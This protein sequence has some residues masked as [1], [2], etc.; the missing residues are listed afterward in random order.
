[1]KLNLGCG[2]TAREGYVNLDIIPGAADV[3]HDLETVPMPFDDNTFEE[4]RAWHVL[5]HIKNLLQLMQELHR[6]AKPDCKFEIVVPY[7]SH[8]AAFEDPTHVR[9]FFSNSF[10]YFAQTAFG[11]V[12]YGYRGDWQPLER[13]I[14][15]PPNA[16]ALK[17]YDEAMGVVNSLRNFAQDFRVIL[18][19]IKPARKLS[20]LQPAEL[21]AP[22]VKFHIKDSV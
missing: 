3:V 1:M 8:D 13:H 11:P 7:G 6:I 5:E 22:K 18:R 2:Q 10:A 15:L 19:A 16:K 4:I 21:E 20:S 9:Q 14:Y 12:D 17:S